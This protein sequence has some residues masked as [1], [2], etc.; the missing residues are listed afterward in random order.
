[1]G[2]SV[3]LL[4]VNVRPL[5]VPDLQRLWSV[6]CKFSVCVRD[7][8]DPGP[9]IDTHSSTVQRDLTESHPALVH[10]LLLTAKHR[11]DRMSAP[12]TR[13]LVT[14]RSAGHSTSLALIYNRPLILHL[15]SLTLEWFRFRAVTSSSELALG[16]DAN[17]MAES[18]SE[19]RLGVRG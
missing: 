13:E 4:L 3:K 7:S 18:Y 14:H 19:R 17:L 16:L 11:P 12:E 1:M 8:N 6:I 9:A 15:M 2:A 5:L 10:D